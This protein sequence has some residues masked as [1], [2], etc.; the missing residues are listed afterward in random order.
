MPKTIKSRKIKK[1]KIIRKSKLNT[2]NKGHKLMKG[3]GEMI[4]G[5]VN[6]VEYLK[7]YDPDI[8]TSNASKPTV[9][10][11]VDFHGN[12]ISILFRW[13]QQDKVATSAGIGII[14]RKENTYL[15]PDSSGEATVKTYV[16]YD[17]FTKKV[18]ESLKNIEKSI[19]QALKM[20]DAKKNEFYC[21]SMLGKYNGSSVYPYYLHIKS[22]VDDTNIDV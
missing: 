6:I 10:D 11:Y 18:I 8:T 22:S 7:D 13:I 12:E 21:L 20:K 9:F 2:K 14:D 1:S 4:G 17:D 5:F 3:G 15:S 19:L 16:E